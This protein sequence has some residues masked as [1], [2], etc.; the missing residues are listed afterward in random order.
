[1]KDTM[2]KK[3]AYF[4]MEYGLDSDFKIYSGGLGIL[5]GDILKAAKDLEKPLV[6]VGILWRQGYDKQVITDGKITD[7]FPEY[8][9]DFLKDTGVTVDVEIRGRNVKL[10]VWLCDCFGNVPLYLLDANIP[11][12]ADRLIT[13]QLYG[14][15]GEE[16][17]AQEM[18]LGIGGVRAL[19]KL[20]IDVDIY[21]FNDSHPIFAGFELIKEKMADGLT[22]PKAPGSLR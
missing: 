17:I 10:K 15:F 12:N 14:W 16:R 22:F 11:E 8:N 5:A 18:I 4:C 1:M 9:Y 2:D 21:H 20:G 7:C 3:V 13:G 19:K 6:A